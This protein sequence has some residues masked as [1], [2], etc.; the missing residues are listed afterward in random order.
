MT[1]NQTA[2]ICIGVNLKGSTQQNFLQNMICLNATIKYSILYKQ[3]REFTYLYFS[4]VLQCS[5]VY[6]YKG[7]NDSRVL[8][9]L[10]QFHMNLAVLC[11]CFIEEHW[12]ATSLGGKKMEEIQEFH[13]QS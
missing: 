13:R 7:S 9:A 11:Q 10:E 4:R 5:T 8:Y 3:S 2:Q 1:D 12:C 6:S